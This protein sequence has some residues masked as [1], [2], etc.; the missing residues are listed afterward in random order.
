MHARSESTGDGTVHG[1]SSEVS[2]NPA[3]VQ[4]R[5]PG[6]GGAGGRIK[7]QSRETSLITSSC[8][9]PLWICKAGTGHQGVMLCV[10]VCPAQL[11]LA[12]GL[13]AVDPTQP[14]AGSA[15]V[16]RSDVRVHRSAQGR[17]SPCPWASRDRGRPYPLS[18]THRSWLTYTGEDGS[19]DSFQN[20]GMPV[21][22][23]SCE[24]HPGMTT[25]SDGPVHKDKA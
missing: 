9:A 7:C 1:G 2:P 20:K 5:D 15:P 23:L 17:E 22:K 8:D 13:S 4:C 19:R 24:P 25:T 10:T 3:V 21:C 16:R 11:S 12:L 6:P 18:D 14:C